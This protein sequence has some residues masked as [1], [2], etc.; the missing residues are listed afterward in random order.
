MKELL[1]DYVILELVL[2]AAILVICIVKKIR[3][4]LLDHSPEA[5]RHR[6][7]LEVRRR[8]RAQAGS[9]R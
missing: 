4:R 7:M 6:A 8:W 1:V 3:C 2:V 9:W 5:E